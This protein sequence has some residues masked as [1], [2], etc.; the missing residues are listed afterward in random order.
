MVAKDWRDVRIEDFEWTM[1][2]DGSALHSGTSKTK[3]SQIAE[4]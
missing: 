1:H 3:K 4:V 2:L